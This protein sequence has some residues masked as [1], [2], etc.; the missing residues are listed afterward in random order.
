MSGSLAISAAL[1]ASGNSS[2]APFLIHLCICLIVGI[3][4]QALCVASAAESIIVR[5][6]LPTGELK[7]VTMRRNERLQS[8]RRKLGLDR[9][10]SSF[11]FAEDPRGASKLSD[12]AILQRLKIQNGQIIYLVRPPSTEKPSL[13]P[14]AEAPSERLPSE[15]PAARPTTAKHVRDGYMP[16]P[17][18]SSRRSGR[19]RRRA[20]GRVGQMSMQD[21]QATSKR[22]QVKAQTDK[23]VKQV[24][25]SSG[26]A[27]W[28]L[29]GIRAFAAARNGT[30]TSV[31]GAALLYG[32]VD[33]STGRITVEAVTQPSA[34]AWR[35]GEECDLDQLWSPSNRELDSA[36]RVAEMLGLR[37]V[38]WIFTSPDE[39]TPVGS[40]EIITAS[41]LQRRC[42]QRHGREEGEMFVSV[43]AIST[44][45]DVALEAFHMSR[46][47]VQ[48][49]SDGLFVLPS[50]ASNASLIATSEPVSVEGRETT[51]LDVLFC[52]IPVAIQS[53]EGWLQNSFP[54]P[55]VPQQNG[56]ESLAA[57][58]RRHMLGRDVRRRPLSAR[59]RD[60]NLLLYVAK[61]VSREADLP[62]LCRAVRD[63][64][65]GTP[66]SSHYEILLE[67]IAH[68]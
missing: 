41:L 61:F 32:T 20:S 23:V 46:Q 54:S 17:E 58:L 24:S 55:F 36:D 31:R 64:H 43:A 4:S 5:V 48:L 27:E 42:M 3:A 7:R 53:H 1:P 6:R 62:V 67:T 19:L 50:P 59:L 56:E 21:L 33:A 22:L 39:Q 68:T 63:V 57:V 38:G 40:T 10:A 51:D 15:P 65:D 52:L 37:L 34:M 35:E 12:S 11:P 60:F 2:A 29:S 13:M 47:A 49:A 30:E 8:I 14:P 9:D 25:V 66:L 44:G 45:N 28:F 26:G 16:Y 18:L